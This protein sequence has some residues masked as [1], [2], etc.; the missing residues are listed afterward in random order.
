MGDIVTAAIAVRK[1]TLWVWWFLYFPVH[2]LCLSIIFPRYHKFSGQNQMGGEGLS[3]PTP[4][5]EPF[6]GNKH[7][8]L[9]NQCH[10]PYSWKSPMYSFV[11]HIYT[12]SNFWTVLSFCSPYESS[13]LLLCL[14]LLLWSTSLPA[15]IQGSMTATW[16]VLIGSGQLAVS[17]PSLFLLFLEHDIWMVIL[18]VKA[19]CLMAFQ[20]P[21]VRSWCA[22]SSFSSW[23]VLTHHVYCFCILGIL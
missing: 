8:C 21:W 12:A 13:C 18:I 4:L 7:Q 17:S 6:L 3:S 23:L 5:L 19:N 1:L 20:S 15:C 22:F 9:D 11:I 10:K 2:P 16:S 14:L